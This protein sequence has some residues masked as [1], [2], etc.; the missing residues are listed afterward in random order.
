MTCGGKSLHSSQQYTEP[1][2]SISYIEQSGR[3]M[4]FAICTTQV[5]QMS[6]NE[7]DLDV[8]D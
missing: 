6:V 1:W 8:E 5:S 7:H 4:E 2:I 3:L